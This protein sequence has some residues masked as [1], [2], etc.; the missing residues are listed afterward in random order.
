VVVGRAAA[1]PTQLVVLAEGDPLPSGHRDEPAEVDV[2]ATGLWFSKWP[3]NVQAPPEETC[4]LAQPHTLVPKLICTVTS[5]YWPA[6][7]YGPTPSQPFQPLR[8]VQ[9]LA[10]VPVFRPTPKT[11]S[12]SGLVA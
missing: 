1:P 5:R 11:L 10:H 4:S 2:K 6:C 3:S 9:E 12:L 7:P 8:E